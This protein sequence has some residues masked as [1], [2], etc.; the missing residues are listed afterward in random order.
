M[1]A[2][3]LSI[4]LSRV[5]KH[6]DLQS[7]AHW[8]AGTNGPRPKCLNMKFSFETAP[9]TALVTALANLPTGCPALARVEKL[10]VSSYSDAQR[11]T[12]FCWHALPV[13]GEMNGT[14]GG[15]RT[16]IHKG[17]TCERFRLFSAPCADFLQGP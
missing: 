4:K 16:S 12:S 10:V 9:S 17:F 13:S 15:L 14:A 5:Q 11:S 8:L 3:V 1:Q 7:L 2:K 6:S